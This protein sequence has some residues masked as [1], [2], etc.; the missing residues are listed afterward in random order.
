MSNV[1]YEKVVTQS[2]QFKPKIYVDNILIK[3]IEEKENFRYL[4]RWFNFDMDNSQHKRQLLDTTNRILNLIHQLPLH[5][6]NKL[7][8]YNRYF[9]SKISWDLTIADIDATWAKQNLDMICH[10]YFRKWLKKV[11][12][13]KDEEGQ[14]LQRAGIEL[15]FCAIIFFSVIC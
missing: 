13:H 8:L 3:S 12:N 2:K 4:G 7:Q 14:H 1:C 6:K 9:L 11:N 15:I 10:G 5:P